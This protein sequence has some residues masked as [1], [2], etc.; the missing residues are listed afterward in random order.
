MVNKP[1]ILTIMRQ[2][3]ADGSLRTPDTPLVGEE[4]QALR[5]EN[6]LSI[7]HTMMTLKKRARAGM[8]LYPT[9]SNNVCGECNSRDRRYG[10]G[11]HSGHANGVKIAGYFRV[12][13]QRHMAPMCLRTR[14]RPAATGP[15]SARP[16]L[17]PLPTLSDRIGPLVLTV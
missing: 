12:P 1:L 17:A 14:S 5:R 10:Q 8:L 11:P 7:G 9:A 6:D 4:S 15:L 3:A 13:I 2:Y 16:T